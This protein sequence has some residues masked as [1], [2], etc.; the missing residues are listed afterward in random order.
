MSL[1]AVLSPSGADRWLRC[2]PSARLEQQFPDTAGSAASEG[3]LAHTLG[4][5][6]IRHKTKQISREVYA[7][8]LAAIQANK[9]YEHAMF[10]HA[11]GYA[12]YVLEQFAEAQSHTKDAIL[13]LEQKLDLTD[14]VPEGFGTGDAV[15]IA[16]KV[17]NITDLKY[18]KGVPVSADNN[19]QM[20]LYSLGALREFDFMYDIGIVRMTIYQPRLDNISTFE[21]SVSDLKA[22]AETELRP[23][24]AE[25]FEGNGD[26]NPGIQCRFCKAKAVCKAHADFNLEMAR[27]DFKTGELLKDKEIAEI[28]CKADVFITWINS[29]KEHALNEALNHDKKWPGFKLVEGKSNRKYSDELAVG[30]KL[31]AEGFKE[32]EIYKKEL[33]GIT[34]LEK[35]IGKKAFSTYLDNLLIK[36]PGKP[37]LVP[38]SDK[39][40]ELNSVEFAK[41]EFAELLDT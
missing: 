9:Q 30:T 16:D 1:H 35:K 7:K 20:M 6:L 39:R 12:V 18:G 29:I 38:E 26:F 19:K 36:P 3:T 4:E 31:I 10:E 11:E 2:T 25:A 8:S 15:I 21:M 23:K 37:T 28:L 22:W 33:R 14:Y 41:K 27:L 5:L 34:E 13:F 40:P 32:E 17:L 24:A